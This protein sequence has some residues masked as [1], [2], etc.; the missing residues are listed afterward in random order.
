MSNPHETNLL[1]PNRRQSVTITASF[2]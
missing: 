1:E 2:K